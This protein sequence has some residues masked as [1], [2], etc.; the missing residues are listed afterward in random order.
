MARAQCFT[1]APELLCD[2]VD[3][4]MTVLDLKTATLYELNEVGAMVWEECRTPRNLSAIAG[5]LKKAY[6]KVPSE[7]LRREASAFVEQLVASGLL[8]C[9]GDERSSS[10]GITPCP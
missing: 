9:V 6:P 5:Q 4:V 1:W 7:T 2:S 10:H 8:R 3:S